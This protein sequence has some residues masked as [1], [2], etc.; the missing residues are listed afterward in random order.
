MMGMRIARYGRISNEIVG[1]TDSSADEGSMIL[2]RCFEDISSN[3]VA[4]DLTMSREPG[5]FMPR[6]SRA[7]MANENDRQN[8]MPISESSLLAAVSRG[9]R[10]R[11]RYVGRC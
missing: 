8:V 11:R 9:F 1:L 5:G 10:L 4:A 3:T 6:A 2:I 7:A